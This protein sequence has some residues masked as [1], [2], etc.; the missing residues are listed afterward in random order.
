[1]AK[2]GGG[3]SRGAS[4][5]EDQAEDEISGQSRVP[6]EA[7]TAS[8]IFPQKTKKKARTSAESSDTDPES[9]QPEKVSCLDDTEKL[10]DSEDA[11]VSPTRRSMRSKTSGPE[12]GPSSNTK[13]SSSKKRSNSKRFSSSSSSSATQGIETPVEPE[14]EKLSSSSK[15]IKQRKSKIP[16]KA[17]NL[18]EILEVDEEV[19]EEDDI[20]FT[21]KG[22]VVEP[23]PRRQSRG[24][25]NFS[26]ADD[27][28]VEKEKRK[29]SSS[30]SQ[31]KR[32]ENESSNSPMVGKTKP[33]ETATVE[34]EEVRRG[35][36]RNSL[37]GDQTIKPAAG[38]RS[39]SQ[40]DSKK[41]ASTEKNAKS[42]SQTSVRNKPKRKLIEGSSQELEELRR[43]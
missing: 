28:L 3:E 2:E 8:P 34:V 20:F 35:S 7:T 1:M 12:E 37:E 6:D 15:E 39:S 36:A 25:S 30:R 14:K 26:E 38:T 31:E 24:K 16:G 4:E 27:V 18:T 40:G 17:Q 19:E 32:G 11:F 23:T 5:V 33:V 41:T 13:T 9:R 29:S 22:V 10:Y 42:Q 21:P 43:Y